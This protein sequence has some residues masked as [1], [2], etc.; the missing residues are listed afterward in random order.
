MMCC[1]TYSMPYY[2]IYAK[3]S[4]EKRVLKELRKIASEHAHIIEFKLQQKEMINTTKVGNITKLY[5]ILPGYIFVFSEEKLKKTDLLD[6]SRSKD[7]FYFL[8]YPD[9]SV[10]LK[11]DDE[12]YAA[13]IF[14]LPS[15]I[16]AS[17]VLIKE[18]QL[19]IVSKG[20]FKDFKAKV[21]KIDKKRHRVEVEIFFLS[22]NTRLSLPYNSVDT[23]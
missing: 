18:G 17:N 14:Q 4:S 20:N 15:T 10:E 21:L 19:V 7:L 1:Y 2:I 6:Y 9:G 8:H 23:I 16:K 13:T 22:R 5:N 11:G 3:S 12:G